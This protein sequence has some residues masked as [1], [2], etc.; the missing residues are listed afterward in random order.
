MRTRGRVVF[1]LILLAAW[2]LR[3]PAWAAPRIFVAQQAGNQGHFQVEY[4]EPKKPLYQ[5]M[6]QAFSSARL[7]E[8]IADS[9][10]QRYV[11]PRDVTLAFAEVGTPNAF[12]H[13]EAHAIIISYELIEYYLLLYEQLSPDAVADNTAGAIVFALYHEL[14]HCL[15]AEL[16]LPATGRE[17]DAVDDFAT[18]LLMENKE[19]GEKSI[20]AASMWFA[21][22][23][24]SKADSTPFWDEHSLDMQRFYGIL[25]LMYGN[26]PDRYQQLCQELGMP[27]QRL[28]LAREEFTRKQKSW[29]RLLAPYR[30]P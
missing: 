19:S 6:H 15:I 7:L 23:A 17:E 8:T 5:K 22:K 25:A 21:A 11:L 28:A 26:A 20:L 13:P 18:L 3:L 10:N 16:D 9:L 12:Y 2:G 29:A 14:G 24:D 1:L 27:E 30:K 4:V